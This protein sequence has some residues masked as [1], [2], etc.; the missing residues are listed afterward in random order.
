MAG[1]AKERRAPCLPRRA[2]L[3]EPK[4]GVA[5]SNNR[6][7]N[8]RSNNRVNG[9]KGCACKLKKN[10]SSAHLSEEPNTASSTAPLSFRKIELNRLV[11]AAP[12]KPLGSPVGYPWRRGQP[13]WVD[14]VWV[15]R[16][17]GRLLA[18]QAGAASQ[19]SPGRRLHNSSKCRRYFRASR[20]VVS[21][22]PAWA[23][24]MRAP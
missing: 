4:P 15:D 14:R 8:S 5:S 3:D 7:E 20:H 18:A 2:P 10:Y 6:A 23:L 19:Q 11:S 1:W 16:V 17:G 21:L 13:V 9:Q 12:R 22:P 24:G